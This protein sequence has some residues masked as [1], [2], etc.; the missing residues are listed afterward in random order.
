MG[1]VRGAAAGLRT[2][3]RAMQ[4]VG[5]T[6][7][8][9]SER[10]SHP[11]TVPG[12]AGL[13]LTVGRYRTPAGIDIDREGIQPDFRSLPSQQAA[14]MAIKACK[15]RAAGSRSGMQQ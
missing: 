2:S 6:F 11:C 5:S 1:Q 14:D 3:A 9:L 15:L 7:I 4:M 10:S 8:W 12:A 13:V